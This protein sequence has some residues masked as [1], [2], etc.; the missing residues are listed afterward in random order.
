M[1]IT[2][3]GLKLSLIIKGNYCKILNKKIIVSFIGLFLYAAFNN[4][5]LLCF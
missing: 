2:I 1:K 5:I 4:M 3:Q